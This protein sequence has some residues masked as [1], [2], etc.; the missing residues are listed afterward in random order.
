MTTDSSNLKVPKTHILING[1]DLGVPLSSDVFSLSVLQDVDA[2]GMF[3]LRMNTWDMDREVL[4]WIDD[5]RF[6]EGNEIEIKMG[7]YD[8]LV[9]VFTGNITALEPEFSNVATPQLI[10]RGYDRRYRLMRGV[11]TRSF[12]QVTDSELVKLIG[13]ELG[14]R[15]DVVDTN[16]TYEYV[17]QNNQ[18]DFN[19]LKERASLIGYELMMEQDTLNFRPRGN[20]NTPVL[21]LDRKRDLIEF[22]PRLTALH[23]VNEFT[24]RAWD[25]R[26]KSTIVAQSGVG[27]EVGLM[28]GQQSGPDNSQ[29]GLGL[30]TRISV[31]HPV[32]NQAEADAIAL[33]SY[34]EMA[35][36]YIEGE[37]LI[38]GRNDLQAGAVITIEG[39]GT[40]FSG[41]YYVTSTRHS[42]T[43]RR[44]Y[45]T[46]FSV[47]RN[48]A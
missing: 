33:G 31:N 36:Q 19:F 14:L 35:L 39:V 45:Q 2:P 37:G 22:T 16:I 3:T 10:V 5:V 17:L 30:A 47:R 15:V 12:S 28:A 32:F 26:T 38:A 41:A 11:K 29:A 9:T 7:Y 4:T 25:P 13:G 8:D 43:P 1:S 20:N 34:N 40:R 48:A 18:S 27:D 23:Q 24:V 46:S 21:S 6:N 44:G 42:Y